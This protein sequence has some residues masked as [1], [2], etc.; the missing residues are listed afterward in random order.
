MLP[1]MNNHLSSM[2]QKEWF[3]IE[4]WRQHNAV[5]GQS[6]GRTV[7]WFI[8]HQESEWVLRHYHRGGM[9]AKIMRD[10][11]WF[12]TLEKTRCFQELILLELMYLQGLPVP[13]PIAAHVRKHGFFYKA[14][15]II[16]KI[17]E[18]EDLVQ[19]LCREKMTES[20]WLSLGSMIAKFHQTGIYHADLNAHNIL[21]DSDDK[22]WLIDF[23]K[24][25]QR[26]R[27]D[28]DWPKKN[29]SRLYRSF[30]K[31][32]ALHQPFHFNEQHWQWFNSGYQSFSL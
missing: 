6:V 25:E 14:D 2:L 27:L 17:P 9:V 19:R 22:F 32:K 13:K 24:C 11:Y 26:P 5:I 15:L 3:E 23:D 20:N 16:E 12:S 30:C 7:T 31:E 29:L 18:S 28:E 10:N 4:F 8:K 1:E 21:L